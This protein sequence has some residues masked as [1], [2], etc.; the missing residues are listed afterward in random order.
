MKKLTIITLSG[1]LI[2]TYMILIAFSGGDRSTGAPEGHTGAPGEQTCAK[3]GCHSDHDLNS[4]PGIL[5]LD[6]ED[7]QQTYEAGKTYD[8]TI[9]IQQTGIERFGFEFVAVDEMG[10]QSAGT[11]M[12]TDPQRTQLMEGTQQFTGKNYVTYRYEGTDPVATGLGQWHFR[13]KAPDTIQG[14]VTFYTAAVSA[15]NDFTDAGDLTYTHSVTISPKVASGVFGHQEPLKLAVYPN[16]VKDRLNYQYH[17]TE[18]ADVTI[19]ITDLSGRLMWQL[20]TG[21]Q[22]PG[23]YQGALIPGLSSGL[24]VLTFRAGSDIR[25]QKIAVY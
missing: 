23:D 16:P 17:L 3:S 2:C 11:I 18:V 25:Y 15:D 13:W 22:I 8:I 14:P 21:K 19:S 24:Y 12:L 4:G 1:L 9:S 20:S 5:T 7:P 6:F 10:S